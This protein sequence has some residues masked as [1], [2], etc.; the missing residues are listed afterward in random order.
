MILAFHVLFLFFRAK[1][2]TERARANRQLIVGDP[3]IPYE[4][5]EN[6]LL[7]LGLSSNESD[8]GESLDP[9]T[10]F[11]PRDGS[12][13]PLLVC[14]PPPPY[15]EAVWQLEQPENDPPPPYSEINAAKA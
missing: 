4:D 6:R 11:L 15:S 13:Q 10:P 8:V 9:L 2:M 3:D 1:K 12:P 5:I 14:D 7:E